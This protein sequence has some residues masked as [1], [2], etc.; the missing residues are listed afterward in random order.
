MIGKTLGYYQITSQLGK[1]DIGEVYKVNR[2]SQHLPK[3]SKFILSNNLA[4]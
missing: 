3:L 4:G 1:G 2:L